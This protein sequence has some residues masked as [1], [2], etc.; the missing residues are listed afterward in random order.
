MMIEELIKQLR[1]VVNTE[2]AGELSLSKGGWEGWLQCEYWNRLNISGLATEREAYYPRSRER[3]DLVTISN[4][5]IELKAFG[6]F[7]EGDESS[8]LKSIAADVYKLDHNKPSGAKGVI[9]V[10][11]PKAIGDDL[12]KVLQNRYLGFNKVDCDYCTICYLEV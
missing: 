11:I 5:W 12:L 4:D 1:S 7:R 10:V 9:F 6:I 3:C 2:I 8:F